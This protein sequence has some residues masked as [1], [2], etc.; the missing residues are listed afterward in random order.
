MTSIREAFDTMAWGPAPESPATAEAWL[1]QHQRAFG[2]FI[3]GA[4]VEPGGGERFATSNPATGQELAKVA[5]GSQPD[6]DA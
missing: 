4:W 6:V 2:H 3:N 1:S 5:Q